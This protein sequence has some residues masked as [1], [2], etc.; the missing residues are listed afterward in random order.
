MRVVPTPVA[1]LRVANGAIRRIGCPSTSRARNSSLE[2]R[3]DALC[4]TSPVLVRSP[5]KSRLDLLLTRN[6]AYCEP[7]LGK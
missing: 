2:R 4:A 5:E 7:S 6:P 1:D 3:I